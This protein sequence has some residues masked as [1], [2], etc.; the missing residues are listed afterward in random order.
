MNL[1]KLGEKVSVV[2][3]EAG[4]M[5]SHVDHPDIY[6]KEGHNNYVTSM[7][8]A[9]QKYIIEKLTPLL[10]GAE[11]LAEEKENAVNPEKYRWIIDPIDGTTNYMKGFG[12]SC[13]SIALAKEETGLLGVVYDIFRGDLYVGIQGKGATLNGKAISVSDAELGKALVIFGTATYYEKMRRQTYQIVEPL[14]LRCGDV[15]R[16]GAAVLDICYTASG[17]ADGFFELYLQ[18]WDYAAG[19]II[20]KEA[21]GLYAPV[22]GEKFDF[23]NPSGI[24]CGNQK[25][26]PEISGL[27]KTYVKT[28]K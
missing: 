13:V 18:P 9:A 20:L 2:A 19:L 3:K 8:I 7:D 16:T 12:H 25:V 28:E 17:K 4:K 22:Y 24:C 6:D 5:V 10:E 23:L 11:F 1:E 21:G 27:L 26:F 14:G 15:R